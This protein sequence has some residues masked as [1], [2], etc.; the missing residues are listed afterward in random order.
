RYP[1]SRF[2]EGAGEYHLLNTCNTWTARALRQAGLAVDPGNAVTAD[3]LMA[4]L[5]P[6]AVAP[7]NR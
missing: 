6:L 5:R 1:G 2:Y 4:Q 3:D 7:E